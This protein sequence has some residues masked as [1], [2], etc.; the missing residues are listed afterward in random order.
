HNAAPLLPKL[1]L[2]L[3]NAIESEPE[4]KRTVEQVKGQTGLIDIPES[5]S[6]PAGDPRLRSVDREHLPPG[7]TYTP[8]YRVRSATGTDYG[9]A[10]ALL[11]L[12]PAADGKRGRILYISN[13]LLRDPENGPRLQRA[14]LRRLVHEVNPEP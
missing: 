9:D 11:E 7:A 1:G 8:I 4:E 2:P 5:F 10:A 12:P 13:V 3:Y 6:Y 14:V